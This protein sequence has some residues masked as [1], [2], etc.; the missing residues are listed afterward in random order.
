MLCLLGLRTLMKQL[1]CRRNL[2]LHEQKC[3]QV[4]LCG[5][6]SKA[7]G[8]SDICHSCSLSVVWK[9]VT[10]SHPPA[11]KAR[12]C[13]LVTCPGGRNLFGEQLDSLCHT[14]RGETM[15]QQSWL[16]S[17]EALPR[18][19]GAHRAPGSSFC[20]SLKHGR[21]TGLTTGNKDTRSTWAGEGGYRWSALCLCC[22]QES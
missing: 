21:V 10:G 15:S 11:E 4:V 20:T 9:A 1:L 7:R 6:F 12:R 8:G 19:L 18:L 22:L 2:P 5:S 16:V 3:R 13:S 17:S 14:W